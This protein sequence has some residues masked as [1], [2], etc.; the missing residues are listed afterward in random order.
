MN[1]TSITIGMGKGKP[2]TAG[3]ATPPGQNAAT[4]SDA[5]RHKDG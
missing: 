5:A 1:E 3:K 2:D 4:S